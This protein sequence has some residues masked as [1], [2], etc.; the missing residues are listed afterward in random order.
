MPF[1]NIRATYLPYC[2]QLQPCGRYAVLNR[3]YK[4]LGWSVR[5]F[6]HYEQHPILAT[7]RITP[8]KAVQ[9]SHDGSHNT[10]EVFLYCDGCNP[11]LSAATWSAYSKR[12]RVLAAIVTDD[13]GGRSPASI[14]IQN[15]VDF[16]GEKRSKKDIAKS[17]YTRL[18]HKR[19][20]I[21]PT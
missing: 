4:P 10:K 13:N 2:L 18:E 6:V 7:I 19:S 11:D 17:V 14:C 5:S 3:E 16:T 20:N 12:L 8:K 21:K 9:L 1:H 15:L